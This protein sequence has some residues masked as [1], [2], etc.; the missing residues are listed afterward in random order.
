[1]LVG[2]SVVIYVVV[3]IVWVGKKPVAQRKNK[4]IANCIFWQADVFGVFHLKNF[5]GFVAHISANFVAQIGVQVAVANQFCGFCNVN[6]A[7]VC[8]DDDLAF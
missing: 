5:F 6:C 8:S 7:V 2:I 3:K 4:Q 1:M